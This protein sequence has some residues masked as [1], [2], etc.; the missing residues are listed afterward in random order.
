MNAPRVALAIV[1]GT[2]GVMAAAG[3]AWV[4][5]P[6]EE[7]REVVLLAPGDDAYTQ[8]LIAGAQDA[9]AKLGI[10]VQVMS[11]ATHADAM[12]AALQR[13]K[14]TEVQG[15][16][17]V[18]TD[19]TAHAAGIS[20]LVAK[21]RVITCG[22]DAPGSRRA[23]H[24]GSGLYSSGSACADLVRSWF[25]QGG[26]VGVL[27]NSEHAKSREWRDQF[28]ESLRRGDPAGQA[29]RWILSNA[30]ANDKNF[31]CLVCYGSQVDRRLLDTSIRARG[32][33]GAKIVICDPEGES[34][35]A[36]AAGQIDAAII[37]D[38]AAIGRTA[39]M[40][41]DVLLR[42]STIELPHP[43]LGCLFVRPRVVTRDSL[44]AHLNGNA[45]AGNGA[46]TASNVN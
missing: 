45:L 28:A 11:L 18:S 13:I 34:L 1:L 22:V 7:R 44:P 21:T 14:A 36:L 31:D 16:L 30:S 9:A 19:P 12:N 41:M 43:G 42:S 29:S 10:T 40:E 2:L 6:P 23:C 33:R 8:A 24:V 4:G 27:I 26:R 20:A 38:P 37:D 3:V 25:P 35:H 15:V 32:R 39:V 17:V 5:L 46:A